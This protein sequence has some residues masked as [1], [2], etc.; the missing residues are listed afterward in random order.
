MTYTRL[1]VAVLLPAYMLWG[2]SIS[3]EDKFYVQDMFNKKKE[4]LLRGKN[5]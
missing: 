3:D 4:F 1:L 5:D 2:N